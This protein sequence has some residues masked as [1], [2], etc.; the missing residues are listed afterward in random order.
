M[1]TNSNTYAF[2]FNDQLYIAPHSLSFLNS[3][4]YVDGINLR[5][6]GTLTSY[7]DNV[8]VEAITPQRGDFN[9]DNQLNAADVSAMEQ[10]LTNLNGYNSALGL[11]DA[12]LLAIADVNNDG[13]INNADLQALLNDL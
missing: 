8:T 7:V 6:L 1:N 9:P 2:L 11:T 12:S 3:M 4:F 10:A 5:A 13:N